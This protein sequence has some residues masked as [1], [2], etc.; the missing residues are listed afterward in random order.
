MADFVTFLGSGKPEATA[1]FKQVRDDAKRRVDRGEGVVAEEK[2][3]VIWFMLPLY[4]DLGIFD[5]ME[6]DLGAVIPMDMVSYMMTDPIDTSTPDSMLKG[7]GR[8]ALNAPMARQLRGPTSFYTNDLVRV[9]EDYQGDVVIFAGHEGCKMAWGSIGL[10]RDTCKELGKP[11]LVMDVDA[12]V[13]RPGQGVAV[14]NKIEEFLSMV[15][16]A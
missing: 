1:V 7:L 15:V 6:Q 12:F 2:V 8:K 3:R 11:L 13:E 9:V 16:P 4:F 5:W 14:R 10:I